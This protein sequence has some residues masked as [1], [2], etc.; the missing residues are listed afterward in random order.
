MCTRSSFCHSYLCP[1]THERGYSCSLPWK[2]MSVPLCA[3]LHWGQTD[4]SNCHNH[5][6]HTHTHA[7]VFQIDS[8]HTNTQQNDVNLCLQVLAIVWT[9]PEGNRP[10]AVILRAKRFC[11]C[12]SCHPQLL[13]SRKDLKNVKFGLSANVSLFHSRKAFSWWAHTVC[14]FP[15]F[16]SMAVLHGYTVTMEVSS[17]DSNFPMMVKT[18]LREFTAKSNF[19]NVCLLKK[20]VSWRWYS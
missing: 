14:L 11:L 5:A 8:A 16:C 12:F 13:K 18:V 3:C 20:L 19:W 2:H 1:N 4:S 17:E 7:L 6:S 10:G 9:V 15:S